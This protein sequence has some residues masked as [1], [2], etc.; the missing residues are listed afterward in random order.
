M[1]I[2]NVKQSEGSH[3]SQAC[4]IHKSKFFSYSY[5][6]EKGSLLK[7]SKSSIGVTVTKKLTGGIQRSGCSARLWFFAVNTDLNSMDQLSTLLPR[8]NFEAEV[9]HDG[10]FC[11]TTQIVGERQNGHLHLV[12]KGEL[13]IEHDGSPA[14]LIDGPSL[15][16]YP[17]SF[18]HRMSAI[19]L[20]CAE[21]VSATV[22]FKEAHRNPLAAIIPDYVK[23]DL[24]ESKGLESTLDQLF[25]ELSK[26][27]SG[28]RLML[29]RL[30]DIIIIHIM[31]FCEKSGRIKNSVLSGLSDPAISRVFEAIHLDPARSW[32]ID[33]MARVAHMSRSKFA[34]YFRQ[35]VNMTP[36]D[37][38]RDYR[39]SVAEILLKENY[40]VKSAAQQIGYASQPAFTRAFIAKFGMPPMEWVKRARNKQ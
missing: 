30:A 21:M 25:Y 31:R 14:L 28:R 5:R 38:L 37:Y 15:V 29:D 18:F 39:M 32:T 26:E 24:S 40:S 13:V 27:E 2:L 7:N 12:R 16:F 19:S 8:F 35:V 1:R 22:H 36:F 34:E 4:L 9:F 33:E 20:S 3:L 17:R 6:I 10:E 23:I 11:G